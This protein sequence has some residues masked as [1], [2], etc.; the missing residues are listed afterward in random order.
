VALLLPQIPAGRKRGKK[1]NQKGTGG[2]RNPRGEKEPLMMC[3]V[4]LSVRRVDWGEK[5]GKGENMYDTH[6]E[7]VRNIRKGSCI[8]SSAKLLP[9]VG[10]GENIYDTH[11]DQVRNTHEEQTEKKCGKMGGKMK[12]S[13]TYQPKLDPFIFAPFFPTFFSSVFSSFQKYEVVD[14]I[15]AKEVDNFLAKYTKYIFCRIYLYIQNRYFVDH[16]ILL[17]KRKD[18]RKTVD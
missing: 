16:C 2:I 9:K 17:K 12:W 11:E 1:K 6:E 10:K 4:V 15:S 7:R 14:K 8:V 3:N 13:R 5:V 18:R